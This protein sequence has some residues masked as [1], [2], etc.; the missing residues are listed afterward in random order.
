MPRHIQEGI[1]ALTFILEKGT[2]FP[3]SPISG[4]LF[5]RIDE[6]N[7]YFR[8]DANTVWILIGGSGIITTLTVIFG[9]VPSE[10]IDGVN[11]NFTTSVDY[12]SGS[13]RVYQNGLRLKEGA[14]NDY[15]TTGTNG[16][17]FN[18]AP[19]TGDILIIDYIKK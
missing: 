14:S 17:Q 4:Q 7:I 19:E 11:V 5:H 18:D 8:N 12:V 2:A 6:D 10:T 1:E 9:E 3:V 15:I 13:L 16:I